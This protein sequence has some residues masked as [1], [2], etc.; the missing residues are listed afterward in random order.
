MLEWLK[1][2]SYYA[3]TAN[4]ASNKANLASNKANL[5]SNK[6]ECSTW[7]DLVIRIV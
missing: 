6:A 2:R 7:L 3:N 4:L 1:Y 5:A